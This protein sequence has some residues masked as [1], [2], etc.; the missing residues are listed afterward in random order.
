MVKSL[1]S[2][3]NLE[4]LKKQAKHLVRDHKAGQ[5]GAFAR[6]KTF[7]PSLGGLVPA[8]ESVP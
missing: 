1:P 4:H 2:S 6:I 7:F 3:P 8:L 5:V